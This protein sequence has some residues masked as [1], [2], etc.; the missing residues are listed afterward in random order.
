MTVTRCPCCK[1]VLRE[2]KPSKPIRE[3]YDCG[4]HIL[5][6]HRWTCQTRQGLSAL[7]H[8]VCSN[9]TAYYR[10]AE[11][12]KIGVIGYK[13]LSLEEVTAATEREDELER[14]F[15]AWRLSNG[16]VLPTD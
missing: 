13:H 4:N 14:E 8:R 7:V 1:Q 2:A 6:N 15:K 10:A 16:R 5:R 9:P 3:C 12:R 11:C